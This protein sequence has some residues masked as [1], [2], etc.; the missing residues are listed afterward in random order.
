MIDT[1]GRNILS[2]YSSN[3]WIKM[4]QAMVKH[5]NNKLQI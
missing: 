5:L 2:I 3:E 4:D 1:N